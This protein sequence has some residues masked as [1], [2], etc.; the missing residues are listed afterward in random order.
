MGCGDDLSNEEIKVFHYNSINNIT[1]LDPAF[2][3]SQTNIWAVHHLHNGLVSLDD[4][5]NIQG[6]LAKRWTISE[7]GKEYKFIL[8]DNVYFHDDPCFAGA[9]GRK[10]V[11]SDFVYS[12]NRIIDKKVN[13][14]GSWIF[15]GKLAAEN[16]FVAENDSTFIL[17]L[18]APFRPMLGILTMQY[19]SVVPKEAVEKYAKNFRANPVGTGPYKFKKWLENQ[20]LFLNRN[21]NYF[22]KN[23]PLLDGV[24]TSF[25]NDRKTAYLELLKGK[26]DFSYGLESSISNEL[27]NREGELRQK[28]REQLQF[29]KAP[30]LNTEYLGINMQEQPANSPLRIKKIRQALNYSIDRK[31]MLRTLRNNVGHPADAGFIPKGLPSYQPEKVNGYSY[32]PEKA[33]QLLKEAGYPNGDGLSEIELLTN[34]DYLDLCTFAARQWEDVGF[35]I[36]I[37]MLESATLRERM[38]NGKAPFFRASWIADYPDGE[39]YLA[40]YYSKNPAPPNYT[41]FSNKR[42]DELYEESIQENNDSLRM[43]LY[44]QMENILLEESPFVILFYDETALF[45]ST[46]I[47][48][49]SR[50]AIN[51]LKLTEVKEND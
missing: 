21:E 39:N 26:I 47:E 33:R 31:Q 23:R 20:A 9:K 35:K 7:D 50:N 32:N 43:E 44:H 37:D 49:L 34:K 19:C 25:M 16:P 10:V 46:K 28:H 36:Q 5:L 4:K 24:R 51:L 22:I 1:S 3:R 45:A 40:M 14:P 27:L 42:F 15:T 48:G 12:L 29:V 2:A 13:S 38:R 18:N 30:F 41:F 8:H 17:K 6:D 11:A